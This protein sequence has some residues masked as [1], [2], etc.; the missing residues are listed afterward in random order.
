MSEIKKF[1]EETK[2]RLNEDGDYIAV[3]TLYVLDKT[4]DFSA[5]Q[6]EATE[7]DKKCKEYQ[8]FLASKPAIEL[9]DAISDEATH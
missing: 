9:K 4:D 6:R 1:F 3:T 5:V 2:K 8:D 7:D